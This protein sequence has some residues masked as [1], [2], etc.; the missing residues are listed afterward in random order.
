MKEFLKHFGTVLFV[1]LLMVK[2][3]SFHIY[4]HHD[5]LNGQ[6]NQ[7]EFCL[8]VIDSQQSEIVDFS[9]EIQDLNISTPVRQEEIILVSVDVHFNL[10]RTD[11]LPRPPPSN[12]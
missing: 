10:Y 6:E 4:D 1:S 2:A 12:I 11:T 5:E 3:S 8:L 9:T 7:C